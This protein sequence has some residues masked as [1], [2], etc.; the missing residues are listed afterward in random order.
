[1]TET[2]EILDLVND[3][4]EIIGTIPRSEFY[5]L[6]NESL[7]YIRAAELFIINSKGQ[8][9]VP[10][11]TAHKKI[12]P[13]GLDYSMGGH[14]SAGETYLQG[15]LREIEE[16]LGLDLTEDDLEF[17]HTF[18]PEP[19]LPYFRTLYLYRSDTAPDY[20]PDDFTSATWMTPAELLAIIEAGAPSKT[21]LPSTVRHLAATLA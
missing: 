8:L 7:G 10:V 18:E 2:E 15:G 17:V 12:A 16:E 21:S 6:E 11:R 4:D 9:W 1:M 3:K 13:N 14:I 5:R 19:G 20:N